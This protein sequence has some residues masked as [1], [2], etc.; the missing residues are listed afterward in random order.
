MSLPNYLANIKSSGIY[1]FVWDKSEVTATEAETLRLVA[2]YSEKG[3]FNTPVYCR[4]A[5]EFKLNFGGISKKLEKRGIFFHRMALQALMS[6]PIIAINLKKF[7]NESVQYMAA[8]GAGELKHSTTGAA[9]TDIYDTSRFWTLSPEKLASFKMP[10]NSDTLN[11]AKPYMVITAADNDASSNTIF[12]RPC[13]S[14]GYDVTLK[15]W[16]TALNEDMPDYLTEYGNM[17]VADFFAEIYVFKGQFTPA[18][19]QSEELKKYF[20][21]NGNVV[22]LATSLTNAFGS[23][24]D[25]LEALAA[26]EN[27]GFIQRYQ[28]VTLPYFKNMSGAYISLD[29][30]FNGDFDSHHMMMHLNGDLLDDEIVSPVDVATRGWD[31]I[32][33]NALQN[34]LEIFTNGTPSSN[35]DPINILTDGSL[36]PTIDVYTPASSES[37]SVEIS[38]EGYEIITGSH[39]VDAN[40]YELVEADADSKYY[41]VTGIKNDNANLTAYVLGGS[42]NIASVTGNPKAIKII[43]TLTATVFARKFNPGERYLVNTSTGI[44]VATV[45]KSEVTPNTNDASVNDL[46]VTF[47]KDCTPISC[48]WNSNTNNIVVRCDNM[49]IGGTKTSPAYIKGYT[50]DESLAKPASNS[51]EDKLAW[52]KK[53]LGVLSYGEDGYPGLIEALTNRS[54]IDYRYIVDTFDTFIE[55]EIKST[56]AILA[57]KK[58]NCMLLSNFPSIETFIKSKNVIFTD[59][60]GNFQMKYVKMGGNPSKPMSLKFGLPS[61]ENGAS[62]CSFNTPVVFSDGTLRTT[63][64]AAAL[65]SNNFMIKYSSRKPYYIV[66]GANY[67]RLRADGLVG[68]EYIFSKDERDILEPMGVNCIVYALRKGTYINSNQTA[69]QSPVTALSKINIRELVIYLQDQIEDLLLDYQWELNDDT[70]RNMIKKKADSIMEN[71]QANHGLYA[72]L[73]VCDR[74]NNTEDVIQNEMIILDTEIEPAFGAGKMVQQLTIRKTGEISSRISQG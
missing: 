32:S 14:T 46:I 37:E 21:V 43:D 71:V 48:T 10:G 50:Q 40:G 25:V 24:I 1:R 60:A 27:S 54:N 13:K 51:I 44:Q 30:I 16:F 26:N 66:A 39:I 70:L 56:L 57:K 55:P 34:S 36:I 17:H 64:P 12:V 49:L 62:F 38:N 31:R 22:T 29:L 45:V 67:G 8:E 9:I 68:P 28:G 2:G 11:V 73:N 19:A 4:D 59:N 6:G 53:I 52:Q 7:G 61:E 33:I 74:N 65:V 35:A 42:S 5:N 69:K 23:K 15:S 20:N 58:E 41:T 72:F 3:K 47:D 18:I 63:V